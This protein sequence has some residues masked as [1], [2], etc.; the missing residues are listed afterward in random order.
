[1]FAQVV[2]KQGLSVAQWEMP[3]SASQ[4]L[5]CEIGSL[6]LKGSFNAVCESGGF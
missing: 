3:H 1:M 2:W 5:T 4:S 6:G